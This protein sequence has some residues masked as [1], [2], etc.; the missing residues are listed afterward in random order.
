MNLQR[1]LAGDLA[2]TVG[3]LGSHGTRSAHLAQHQSAGRTAFVRSR[4][5]RPPARFSP[6][7]AL[8]NITQ[9]ES[10]G[11]SNYD[12]AWMSLTKRLSRGLQLETSY[13][14]SKS[15]DTNSLNSSRLRRP[16]RL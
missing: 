16:E 8:G 4:P 9:V 7:S 15:L 5:C 12:A 3:Y 14:W 6:E 11:F 13:T 2:A 10:S 1:Q